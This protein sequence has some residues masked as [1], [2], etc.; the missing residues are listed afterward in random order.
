MREI[1]ISNEFSKNW[2]QALMPPP[3]EKQEVSCYP[4]AAAWPKARMYWPANH[5][6]HCSAQAAGQRGSLRNEGV[7]GRGEPGHERDHEVLQKA[8]QAWEVLKHR[9]K[10]RRKPDFTGFVPSGTIC[11]LRKDNL[12]RNP[13]FILNSVLRYRI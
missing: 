1:L 7:G 12:Y 4:T 2:Q 5:T 6:A 13:P 8:Q 10:I 3:R 9:I 11:Y